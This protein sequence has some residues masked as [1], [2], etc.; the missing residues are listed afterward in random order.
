MPIKVAQPQLTSSNLTLTPLQIPRLTP[1]EDGIDLHHRDAG[2]VPFSELRLASVFSRDDG[3]MTPY[4]LML[5]LAGRRRPFLAAA[6][7]IHYQAF[8]F[9]HA[10]TL[11]PQLRSFTRYLWENNPSL[12]VDRGTF[13]FLSGKMPEQL[14]HEVVMLATALS[15][16]LA[17]VDEADGGG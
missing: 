16:L 15:D 12:A 1:A 8:P 2:R 6:N 9:P 17:Q 5:F 4:R 13:D 3:G 7:A 14:P 11:V 10:E